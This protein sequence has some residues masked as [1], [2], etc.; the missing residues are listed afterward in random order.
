[1]SS[2]APGAIQA[3]LVLI[4]PS[5]HHR[6]IPLTKDLL[7]IGRQAENDIP[8]LERERRALELKRT[9]PPDYD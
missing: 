7:T 8:A 6:R 4:N 5:G 9:P 1:M 2:A 3:A